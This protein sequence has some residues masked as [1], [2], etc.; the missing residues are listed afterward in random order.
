MRAY[1]KGPCCTDIPT[2]KSVCL[3]V[4]FIGEVGCDGMALPPQVLTVS[5]APRPKVQLKFVC[6]VNRPPPSAPFCRVTSQL[7]GTTLP[8]IAQNRSK[9]TAS[10]R[11]SDPGARV[12]RVRGR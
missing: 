6:D 2:Y 3:V 10:A 4:Y 8:H 12:G 5:L 7:Y 1:L 9:G 11:T